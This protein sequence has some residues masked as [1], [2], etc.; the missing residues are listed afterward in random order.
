[1]EPDP[2]AHLLVK[3]YTYWAVYVYE[4]QNYLGRC[5]V[6]CKRDNALDITDATPEELTELLEVLKELR[7]ALTK[8]FGADWM[9]YAFLGNDTRHLHGHVIPRYQSP[10]MFAGTQ[11]TDERWGKNYQT[12]RTFVVGDAVL[13][14]IKETITKELA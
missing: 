14:Q 9:N 5:I 8:A 7:S 10:R 4:W 6:W 13:Q 11:F 1:M 3:D 12:D 2:F